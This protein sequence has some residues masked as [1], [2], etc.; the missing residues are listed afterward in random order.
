MKSHDVDLIL[1]LLCK[2]SP[3]G[4]TRLENINFDMYLVDA[5]VKYSANEL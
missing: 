1:L 2:L 3:D 5:L 4:L